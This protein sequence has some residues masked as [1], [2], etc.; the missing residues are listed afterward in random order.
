MN[1]IELIDR[2]FISAIKEGREPNGSLAQCLPAM[3]VMHMIEEKM[4]A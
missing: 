1:G 3:Q 4:S 2:E